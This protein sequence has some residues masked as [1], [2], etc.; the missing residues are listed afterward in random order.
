MVPVSFSR[1]QATEK[2]IRFREVRRVSEDFRR[3]SPTLLSYSAIA[4]YAFWLYASGPAFALLRAELHFSYAVI[5]VYSALW[6][7]GV[8]LVGRRGPG[9]SELRRALGILAGRA[10]AVW[11]TRRAGRTVLLLW[12]SLVVTAAGFLLF[13]L[14]DLPVLA[15]TGLFVCGIGVANLYPLSLA[16]ALAT[17]SDNGDAAQAAVQLLGGGFVIVAPFLLGSLADHVGLHA[18]F[19]V[20]LVL[21]GV[22]GLLLLA[23]LR[24]ARRSAEA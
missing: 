6:S 9:R 4:A 12:A 22:S 8:V 5:G 15:I 3:D 23:G 20:E 19:A 16:L 14:A 2:P 18:A 13:W 24:L 21:I 1:R 10:A 17:A 11:L 7:G